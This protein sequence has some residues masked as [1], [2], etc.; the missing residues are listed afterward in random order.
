MQDLTYWLLLPL[1]AGL[2]HLGQRMRLWQAWSRIAP[3]PPGVGPPISL[4]I[5]AHEEAANLRRHLRSW[6]HLPYP[7]YEVV[8]VLDRCTDG[9]AAIAREIAAGHPRLRLVEV[10]DTPAGWAPKKWALTQG[11]AAARHAHLAFTDADCAPE[12][13]WLEQ[14]GRHFAAGKALVLGLGLYHRYPGWL[15]RLVQWETA[16]AAWQY[17]GRAAAG[18]PYMAVGRNLAYTRAFFERA[19][20]L[21]PWRAALS[22]DDDLLVNAQGPG[23]PTGLMVTPGSRTWSEPPRSWGAWLA[24]KTRHVSASRHYSRR[25][26][27]WLA[28][29]HAGHGIFYLGL[30]IAALLGPTAGPVLALY[31]GYAAVNGLLIHRLRRQGGL[32]IPAFFP[33]LD[34]L[35]FVYNSTIVPT[36][37]I[38]APSWRNRNR[39]YPKIPWRIGS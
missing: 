27:A 2:L 19:G 8:L 7:A 31:L 24:Q 34:F 32:A 30:G 37:L 13:G 1:L 3:P 18:A 17:L 23:T 14:I 22:G 36:G 29:F 11:I 16:Y 21:A 10:A 9:S 25:S 33:I 38:K 4:V 28:A 5:C 20:G 15:N 6:L 26:Q 35:F 12:P 39:K